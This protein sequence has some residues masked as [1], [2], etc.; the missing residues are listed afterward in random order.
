MKSNYGYMYY[1][2]ASYFI[3]QQLRVAADSSDDSDI[4]VDVVEI[5]DSSSN[6]A[7]SPFPSKGPSSF[8]QKNQTASKGW[9]HCQYLSNCAPTPPLSQPKK[10]LLITSQVNVGLGEGQVCSFSDTVIDLKVGC[11][12]LMTEC[13]LRVSSS[14]CLAISYFLYFFYM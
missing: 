4:E 2:T 1:L 13:H 5:S 9:D 8:P 10:N 6:P 14:Y 12:V 11:T 3:C 7:R